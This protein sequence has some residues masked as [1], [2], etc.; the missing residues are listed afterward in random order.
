MYVACALLV[1]VVALLLFYVYV[2]VSNAV[3]NSNFILET[4][5]RY[6]MKVRNGDVVSPVDTIVHLPLLEGSIHIIPRFHDC[7]RAFLCR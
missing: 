1:R 7:L 4:M 2:R 3:I 6:W 5:G